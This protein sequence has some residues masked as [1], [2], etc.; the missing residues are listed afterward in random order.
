MEILL[1]YTTNDPSMNTM[2]SKSVMGDPAFNSAGSPDWDYSTQNF[3]DAK[4][5]G[6]PDLKIKYDIDWDLRN[7]SAPSIG[8]YE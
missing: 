2:N 7:A 3:S 5:N 1:N 4:G 6:D 8:A